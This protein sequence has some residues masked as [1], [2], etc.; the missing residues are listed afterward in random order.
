[1]AG[2]V[3]AIADALGI[4]R[5]AVL[6]A[7]GGGPHA[8]ACAAVLGDRVRAVGSH[9]AVAPFDAAGLDWFADMAPSGVAEFTAASRGATDVLAHLSRD[10]PEDFDDFAAA[11]MPVFAG[12]YGDWLVTSA[13][14]ALSGGYTGAVEDDLALV[15]PW[16]FE[17]AVIEA[18][19]LL[20]QGGADRFVP[21]AHAQWLA[22]RCPHA[23]LR[24]TPEDGHISVLSRMG[25]TVEWLLDRWADPYPDQHTG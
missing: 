7:S 21:P 17:P 24:L 22:A 23:E 3:E 25:D 13:T 1:V 14:E 2:D 5:F 16:G 6:G 9:A 8:L 19:V 20:V 15:E 4:A 12:P 10:A 18:P 11:D